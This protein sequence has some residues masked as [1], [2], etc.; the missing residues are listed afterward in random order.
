MTIFSCSGVPQV[1]IDASLS[2]GG[3]D[4]QRIYV[5][6]SIGSAT[7]LAHIQSDDL[8]ELSGLAMIGPWL[9]AHDDNR[10]RVY[11]VNADTGTTQIEMIP[12]A[13]DPLGNGDI[14]DIAVMGSYVMVGDIGKN[15]AG[16]IGR[17]VRFSLPT[18]ALI[19]SGGSVPVPAE[20]MEFDYN[21]PDAESLMAD[22]RDGDLYLVSKEQSPKLCALGAFL[23]ATRTTPICTDINP[24]IPFPS[25]ADI[26]P[27]GRYIV[28]RN[29]SQAGIWLRQPGQT[30][31]EALRSEPCPFTSL[32]NQD[33]CNGE[34]ITFS[35]DGRG[36][37]SASER[38]SLGGTTCPDTHLHQYTLTP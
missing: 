15:H 37:F 28:I 36:L 7:R 1:V 22:P 12:S 13:G 32:E 38:S 14:E 29:E 9:L 6:P 23:G 17:I 19:E 10:M 33:E 4:A 18:I 25:A 27:R 35:S 5:C 26:D 3:P 34:A 2:D 21:V 30:V 11:I 31:A 16:D 24:S 20:T 8:S